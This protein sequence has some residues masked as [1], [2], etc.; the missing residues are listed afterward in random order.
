MKMK[1]ARRAMFLLG[2]LPSTLFSWGIGGDGAYFTNTFNEEGSCP[3]TESSAEEAIIIE[4]QGEWLFKKAFKATNVNYI[5]DGSA[6]NLRMA[7]SGSYVVT[8]TVDSGVSKVTFDLGRASVKV[9]T[10]TDGGATWTE[11]AQTAA[12]NKVSVNVNSAAVNRVKIAND[13]SKDADIDNVTVYAQNFETPVAVLTGDASDITGEGATLSGSIV[14]NEGETITELGFVWSTVSKEPSVADNKAVAAGTASPFTAVLSGLHEGSTV[15]YRAYAAYAGTQTYG[16]VKSFKTLIDESSQTVDELG[17]YFVQDFEDASTFPQDAGAKNVEYYVSGQGTWIYNDAYKSTN[18]SY[19]VNGSKMN[20]RMPKN[21]SYVITPVLNSGVKRVEWDQ[22][23]K[24]CT[25][26]ISTDGGET[27]TPATDI[28]SNGNLRTLNVGSLTANRVKI[29]NDTGSDADIDNLVVYAQAFGTPA[30]VATGS[31]SAITKN[32]AEVSGK[33]VDG[34]DQPISMTGVIWSLNSQPGLADNVIE[35]EDPSQAE[36]SVLITGLKAGKT[37]YYRAFALSNAGYAFGDVA[38]F[39]TS[40]ATAATVVTSET[41]K[42]GSKYRVGGM[43]TDDGGLDLL[44]TGVIYGTSSLAGI[45]SL[46][47]ASAAG[48]TVLAMS[49]PS[50][51]FSTS[52]SLDESTLY[53]V[54]AYAVTDFGLALGDEKSFKTDEVV[55][56]PDVILGDIIWCAPDG[57][58]ATADGSEANPFFDVQKAIDLAQPGDRI[59]MKAGTYVYNKRIDI[60]DHNGEPDKYI[61]LWGY[62]GRAVLDFSDMPYHAH[63]NNPYQGIR[64]T[65]SYWHFKNLDITNA[66]DNGMLIERNKPTGGSSSD[67]VNRTQDAHDNIIELCNFYRNG[68]TGLQIKNLGAYNKIINCDSY[69]NCDEGEGDAD[70]FAPKLSVGDGNYFYG[71]RAW[72]NSDDGWDVFYKKEGGF[73]DNMTIILEN[74]ISY[75]NGF[76]DLDKIAPSGNGNGFKCGSD[77]GA[78]N[79]YM[80]RCLAIHNKAKGFDQNHNAGDI[81]LNNCTGMTLTSISDKAYSYRIYES[82][83]SGHEVRLTNCIAIN[84]NARTDKKPDDPTQHGKQSEYG[85]FQIDESLPGMTVTNCE[86]QRA[87]PEY[88][89]NIE[90]HEELIAP[91]DEDGNIPETTFAHLREGAPLIDAGVIIEPVTY[92]GIAVNGIEYVGEAPDLGAFEYDGEFNSGLSISSVDNSDNSISIFTS[93]NGVI[94]VTVNGAAGLASYQASL[95]DLSGRMIHT[96][97]FNGA[98]TA[99][100]PAAPIAPGVIII[101][102]E[103]E[104]GFKAAAKVVVK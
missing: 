15:Y 100:N 78:M 56:T 36:F 95:Y 22:M 99:V 46:E 85:R 91:R 47:Q 58:D 20:L 61:E 59:W 28:T 10:S 32:S 6:R 77:Q 13:A 87:F 17:R 57:N 88:F 38:N 75:K 3:E 9:Y 35:T 90:N 63:S 73:G 71:C 30:T 44:E 103:G 42:S 84:D 94:F 67:I 65:S 37:I 39:V 48:A 29:S 86:F 70:G 11:A 76:L 23:R 19:N 7:K 104:N 52:V 54:R 66:S 101:A 4:G 26:F 62:Q 45:G 27:W 16:D 55:E 72:A 68:D 41:T 12:G 69:L 93:Q 49:R 18:S 74:C 80:N 25:A 82:I 5:P 31:A 83:A 2:L 14:K 79:V 89:V 50:S 96:Q 53:Y 1:F 24:E 102:V 43:V 97:Q 21:G 64:H 51:K 98:T 33:I 60:N 40:P 34:G 81:I 8:P 92:R